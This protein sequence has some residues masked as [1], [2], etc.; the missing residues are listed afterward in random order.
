[1]Y[2]LNIPANIESWFSN[3]QFNIS[4][5]SDL[6][7]RVGYG[8]TGNQDGLGNFASR[9]LNRANE[10]Y[11]GNPGIAQ[12]NVPNPNLGWESTASTNIGIDLALL[13]A[14]V[15]ITADAYL[16]KTSNLI[17]QKQLPWTSG[18]S[19][20]GNANIGEMENRGVELTL[21]TRNLRGEFQG[22]TDFNI[23]MLVNKIKRHVCSWRIITCP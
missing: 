12:D 11:D 5:I 17:F 20:I 8:V 18:F 14:R 6:K 13:N 9:A 16:K 4:A 22:T 10:N 3:C 21:S 19:S 1:M 15:N 2:F 23:A 7:L